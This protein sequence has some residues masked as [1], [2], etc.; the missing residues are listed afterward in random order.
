MLKVFGQLY[1]MPPPNTNVIALPKFT[2]F[3]KQISF[4]L[5][6]ETQPFETVR[7]F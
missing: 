6:G 4:S 2:S 7:I 1:P 5:M 3:F